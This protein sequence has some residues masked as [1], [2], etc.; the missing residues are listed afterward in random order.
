[1]T[2]MRGYLSPVVHPRRRAPVLGQL[3][4]EP[5]PDLRSVVISEDS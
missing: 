2:E 5:T 4:P 1:M 3:I